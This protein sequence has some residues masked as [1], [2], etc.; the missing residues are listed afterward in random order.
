MRTSVK[1]DGKSFENTML[2]KGT[3][4][5]VIFNIDMKQKPKIK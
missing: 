3:S 2:L 4:K 1:Q 5:T